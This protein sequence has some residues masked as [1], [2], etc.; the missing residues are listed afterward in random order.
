MFGTNLCASVLTCGRDAR[1]ALLEDRG[2][3]VP[4]RDDAIMPLQPEYSPP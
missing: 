2:K 1:A 4:L 3:A